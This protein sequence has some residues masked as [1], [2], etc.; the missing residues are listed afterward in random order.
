MPAL[1]ESGAQVGL[2]LVHAVQKDLGGRDTG[3]AGDVHLTDAGAVQKQA[4]SRH[5]TGHGQIERCF[6][7]I[8]DAG[9][10]GIVATERILIGLYSVVDGALIIDIGNY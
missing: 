3:G 1:D 10:A 7:G 9:G 8:G 2:T 4:V 6:A 5:Q